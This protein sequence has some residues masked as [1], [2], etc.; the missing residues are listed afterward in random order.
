MA[1]KHSKLPFIFHMLK[2]RPTWGVPPVRIAFGAVLL[3]HGVSRLLN[4]EGSVGTIIRELPTEVALTVMVVFSL[5]EII[6]GL[7]IIPG[8]LSRF[9][10]FIIVFEMLLSI[11]LEKIPFGYFGD[12]RLDLLLFAIA[13][14]ISFSGPG[15]FSIDRWIARK[16]L[17]K[18]P[19]PHTK[20]D[21]YVIAE[22]RHTAW[23][24]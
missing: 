11:V 1:E 10:G 20:H 24:E 2:T 17:E 14:M 12:V 5:T 16:I 19:N 18:H 7:M 22:T 6:G 23:Y 4:L 21:L 15:R 9:V 3:T 8:I 13:A